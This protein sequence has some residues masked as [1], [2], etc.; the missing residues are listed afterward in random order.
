MVEAA[1][2]HRLAPIVRGQ[3]RPG[4]G[5]NMHLERKR[6]AAFWHDGQ[7]L[8]RVGHPPASRH[9]PEIGN[10]DKRV[11]VGAQKP[12]EMLAPLVK[13]AAPG[14]LRLFPEQLAV[15]VGAPDI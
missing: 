3:Q 5:G 10:V 4:E 7:D 9:A 8:L 13:G 12:V 14:L 1:Q 15:L 2:V 6:R 11:V